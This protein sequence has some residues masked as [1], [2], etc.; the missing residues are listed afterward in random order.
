M[1]K[2]WVKH[3]DVCKYTIVIHFL[4]ADDGESYLTEN[5]LILESWGD[6][7]LSLCDFY[8]GDCGQPNLSLGSG[9]HDVS[10]RFGVETLQCEKDLHRV[11]FVLTQ[12]FFY[13]FPPI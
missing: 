7:F 4:P 3:C 9:G 1:I 12:A 8:D 10:I 5:G 2:K 6:D 11:D 13:N